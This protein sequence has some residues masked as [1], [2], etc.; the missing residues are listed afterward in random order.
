MK[1]TLLALVITTCAANAAISIN[2]TAVT[3]ARNSLG[4]ASVPTG[5]LALLIVD[6]ANNGFIGLANNLVDGTTFST[7]SDP[8]VNTMSAGLT[9]GSTFG[10]DYVLGVLTTGT[11]SI[12][13]L[14]SSVSVASYLNMKFAVVWFDGVNTAGAPAKAAA[15]TKFGIVRGSDWVF[16]ATDAGDFSLDSTDSAGAASFF[17]VNANVPATGASNF[18]TILSGGTTGAAAFTI[19]GPAVPEPSAVLLGAIGALG[20]LRRRRN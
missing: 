5:S 18:R 20:L 9:A 3:N 6:T 16:P 2:G 10:G 7:T 4:T 12:S 19:A 17:Q 13:G 1:Q 15:G 11:G 8:N 14:L